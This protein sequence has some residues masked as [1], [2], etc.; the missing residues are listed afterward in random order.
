MIL[1]KLLFIL[2]LQLNLFAVISPY[3]SLSIEEKLEIMINHFISEQIQQQFPAVPVKE[4]LADDSIIKPLD[5]ELYYNYIHRFKNIKQARQKEQ[6]EIDEKFAGEIAYYKGR[7]NTLK[8]H[9]QKKENLLP[10]LHS[11]INKSYK[12]F[13]GQPAV[14]NLRTSDGKLFALLYSKD[15][16]GFNYNIEKELLINIPKEIYNEVIDNYRT[17]KVKVAFSYE[18]NILSMKQVKLL[19]N[20]IWYDG[21]FVDNKKDA[22]KLDIKINDDIFSQLNIDNIKGKK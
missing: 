3:D 16:Y 21:F 20:D 10:L 14:K 6:E 12:I 19:Y 8:K 5:Y 15:I 18:N 2:L 11:S 13:Y 22:I 7:V 9:Y 17:L 1:K 4:K